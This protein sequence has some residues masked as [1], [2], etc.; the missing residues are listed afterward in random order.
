M[1]TG[2]T[3]I[4]TIKKELYMLRVVDL[5]AGIGGLRQGALKAIEKA[6]HKPEI[7][8]TSEIKKHAVKVLN[9][10][11]SNDKV[12]GD[13]TKVP[14]IN[15]PKHDLLLA[16][17]PCQAFSYAGKRLGFADETKGTLFFHV[18]RILKHHKPKY[19]VL[20][21]VEGLITHDPD[22]ENK[23]TPYGRTLQTILTTL[24]NLGYETS[25]GLFTATD[26]G[27]P[28]LRK[29]VFIVGSLI[30]KP[31]LE[32]ITRMSSEPLSE[33][34]ETG[35]SETDE[36]IKNFQQLLESS[37]DYNILE[38]LQGS[39]FRD[40]RGG[41]R[42]IHS[43]NLNFKGETS[44]QERILLE[45]LMVESKRTKWAKEDSKR[46]GEGFPLTKEQ[47]K[48]FVDY[49]DK[50]L[51]SMVEK[52]TRQGYLKQVNNT[53]RISSGKLT[54]PISHILH[55]NGY[56]NTLVATDADRLVILDNGVLRRF[57]DIEIKRLFGFPDNFILPENLSRKE[58]FDLFGNS[59]VV[60][61]AE[62]VTASLF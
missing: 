26:F 42:N 48:T 29:R 7:V 24:E 8:F 3:D 43:W 1:H 19:F 36:K 55:Q 30:K 38:S 32:N 6:G 4:F 28:Q 57:T 50:D 41:A 46:I 12:T 51:T 5:F 37:S 18:A 20:E 16:G 39:I 54:M 60:P 58:T 61:V 34:L 21:N 22:P 9:A 44:I 13:I 23:T 33:F 45:K 25:W 15:I 10:N 27:V 35:K 49:E 14:E 56:A 2:V 52:L 11:W 17:F 53:Y 62:S 31:D 47:I 59:V 40:W